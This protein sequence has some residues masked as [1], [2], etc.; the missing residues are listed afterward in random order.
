MKRKALSL[1]LALALIAG[2]AGCTPQ[3][4]PGTTSTPAPTPSQSAAVGGLSFTPGTYEGEADGFHGK[5]KVSVTTDATAIT[6]VEVLSHTETE[7]VGTVALEKLPG[8]IVDGQTLALDAVSGCTFTSDGLL[9]A[10]GNALAASGVDMDALKADSGETP[11]TPA[12]PA[13]TVTADLIIVGAG[14]AGLT[15]AIRAAEA[16]KKVIVLEKMPF[17]GGA[18]STAG[19]GT[20]VCGTKRQTALGIEDSPELYFMDMMRGGHYKVDA[21]LAWLQANHSGRMLDW[22][23]DDLGV[24]YPEKPKFNA[25]QSVDRSFVAIGGAAAI[26]NTITAYAENAGVDIRLNTKATTLIQEEG[27]ITG[28]ATEGEG[29]KLANYMGDA[30]LLAT[31][32]F[33]NNPDLMAEEM[34]KIMYYGPSCAT[35]DGLIMAVDVG[36]VTENMEYGA[37]HPNGIEVSPNFG[38]HTQPE[39]NAIFPA[40]GAIWVGLD[41]NRVVNE[42]GLEHDVIAAHNAQSDG[43]LYLV[44]DQT[45]FDLYH[46]SAVG[47]KAITQDEFD[48]WFAANGASEPVFVKNDTLEGACAVVGMDAAQL[49]ASLEQFNGFVAAGEDTDFGRPV[50]IPFDLANGPYYII[51]NKLRV[52]TTLGGIIANDKLQVVDASGE[53]I[54]GLYAAGELVSVHGTF[55]TVGGISWALTS[56][57]LAG[58]FLSEK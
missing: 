34:K 17:T 56:G 24:A 22:L 26:I 49:R 15:A 18:T 35:G 7:G 10:V 16:G 50:S 8:Q 13:E 20:I 1:L 32:G 27:K 40:S 3:T 36:A 39:C 19:G 46:T 57:M 11:I 48:K 33:G 58:E 37:V 51:K 45:A 4:K 2:L 29:G 21:S 42:M 43:N 6:A 55:N 5:I 9:A 41:G 14:A 53:P 25:E 30:V 44:M 31:G 47:R 23:I 54:D 28:V 38:R 12:G 52:A